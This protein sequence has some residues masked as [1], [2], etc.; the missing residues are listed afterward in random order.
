MKNFLTTLI[1]IVI[2][3]LGLTGE[4]MA[5][6]KIIS[7]MTLSPILIIGMRALLWVVMTIIIMPIT[8]VS[9]LFVAAFARKFFM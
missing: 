2:F 6:E 9:G 5:I 7:F 1:F 8:I 3:L 4:D